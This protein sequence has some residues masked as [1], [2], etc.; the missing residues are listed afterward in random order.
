MTDVISHC[1]TFETLKMRRITPKF[2]RL[3]NVTTVASVD[4]YTPLDLASTIRQIVREE[5]TRHARP[6]PY[7]P[8]PA[9]PP[10]H[11]SVSIAA[12][13]N[14]DCNYRPPSPPRSQRNNYPLPRY[15]DHFSY[16]HQ[17]ANTY[18]D[19]NEDAPSPPPRQRNAF[20]E[21]NAYHQAPVRGPGGDH[22]GEIHGSRSCSTQPAFRTFQR[23]PP[24]ATAPQA[25]R[26]AETNTAGAGDNPHPTKECPR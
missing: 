17:P 13:G 26:T 21:Y 2:G 16:P 5:L 23:G 9:P 20:Q 22:A 7:E 1:R 25:K 6:T 18:Y 10:S 8:T 19:P 12:A 3:P 15:E 4:K 14:D 24:V 11:P